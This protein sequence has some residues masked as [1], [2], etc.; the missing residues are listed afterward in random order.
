MKEISIQ[1]RIRILR[2]ELYRISYQLNY[3][4]THPKL[5]TISQQLDH[6]L[7]QYSKIQQKV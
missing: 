1:E 4:L 5:V 6:L 7:N 2:E 3:E